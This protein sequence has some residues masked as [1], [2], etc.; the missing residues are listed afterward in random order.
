[1]DIAV[2]FE[3]LYTAEWTVSVNRANRA[4]NGADGESIAA[5]AFANLW[6]HRERYDWSKPGTILNRTLTNAIIDAR[7]THK[8]AVSLYSDDAASG[9]SIDPTAP[10]ARSA[11]LDR[12]NDALAVLTPDQ[13]VVLVMRAQDRTFGQIAA[14]MH[15]SEDAAKKLAKR[16]RAR[17][18]RLAA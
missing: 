17:L 13:R 10:D 7:R 8:D 5:Q 2:V 9:L 18:D 4:Y 3:S 1:M 12:L 15:I 11:A 14:H 16:A 6:A